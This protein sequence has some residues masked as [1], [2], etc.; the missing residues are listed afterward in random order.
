MKSAAAKASGD[1]LGT[2]RQPDTNVRRIVCTEGSEIG[3]PTG[4]RGAP[5]NLRCQSNRRAP[6]A[7]RGIRSR[8]DRYGP[9]CTLQLCTTVPR[10]RKDCG[11]RRDANET[12]SSGRQ[13]RL[14]PCVIRNARRNGKRKS[15]PL[16]LS[17]QRL[18]EKKDRSLLATRVDVG[19][20]G[21]ARTVLAPSGKSSG[22]FNAPNSMPRPLRCCA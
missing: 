14:K 18:A 2:L 5:E 22:A 11:D 4:R 8:N 12:R 21:S 19:I 15:S 1:E 9:V 16:F 13:W 7:H 10:V 3:V 17:G 20:A 6:W